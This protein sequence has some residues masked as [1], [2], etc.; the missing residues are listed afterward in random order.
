MPTGT[1]IERTEDA[2]KKMLSMIDSIA[3]KKNVAITSS[4]VGLHPS[5]YA[6]NP[7]FL[8][9][10]GPH[11]AVIKI[12]LEKNSGSSIENLKEQLRLSVRKNMPF[13]TLLNQQI[14]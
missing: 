4:Y 14:G 3:G 11:E 8:Y 12:N 5:V 13:F 6:I 2:T 7:I 9:T 10:S 1:R